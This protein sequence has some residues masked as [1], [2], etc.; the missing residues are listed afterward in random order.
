MIRFR[1]KNFVAPLVAGLLTPTNALLA[2]T[3]GLSM[4]QSKNQA[5]EQVKQ[6]EETKA[7]LDRQTKALNKIAKEAKSNP[8]IAQHVVQQKQMSKKVKLFAAIPAG[9][10]KI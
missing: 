6:A 7:A 3:A 4:W 9:A 10:I 1:Q 8:E 5:E 2:G